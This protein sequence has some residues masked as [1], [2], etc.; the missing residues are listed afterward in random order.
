MFNINNLLIWIILNFILFII[1]YFLIFSY[2]YPAYNRTLRFKMEYAIKKITKNFYSTNINKEEQKFCEKCR[3]IYYTT[4]YNSRFAKINCEICKKDILFVKDSSK[5]FFLTSKELINKN[6][7]KFQNDYQICLY[8]DS[9]S[10]IYKYIEKSDFISIEKFLHLH[11]Y[12]CVDGKFLIS[13][14]IINN[15]LVTFDYHGTTSC[16]IHIPFQ[17]VYY[18][19]WTEDVYTLFIFLNKN[20]STLLSDTSIESFFLFFNNVYVY[21][22]GFHFIQIV[23]N[24]KFIKS[25]R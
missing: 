5:I 23:K 7:K 10:N 11:D 4:E 3:S 22:D 12:G 13:N 21:I 25:N 18:K 20:T 19:G 1:W 14:I 2:I 6:F 9:F 16:H 24:Y 15:V 8:I 17:C